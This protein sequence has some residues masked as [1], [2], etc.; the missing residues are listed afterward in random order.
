MEKS[1]VSRRWSLV[2]GLVTGNLWLRL[3]DMV[4]G[5]ISDA[6]RSLLQRNFE[7]EFS[8]FTLMLAAKEFR[9]L[10]IN[11]TA[12]NT[13]AVAF[14]C[15]KTPS[16]RQPATDLLFWFLYTQILVA[17]LFELTSFLPLR[18]FFSKGQT[19]SYEVQ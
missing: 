3:I 15:H 6:E 16:N 13:G 5:E 9:F 14:P 2:S 1:L 4:A 19:L 12:P 8:H 17:R 10:T 11:A 18:P 7:G